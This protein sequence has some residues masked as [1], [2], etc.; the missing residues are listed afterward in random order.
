MFEPIDPDD[1]GDLS[2]LFGPMQV[3]QQIRQAITMCWMSLP[4]ERRTVGRV[5]A[6]VRRIMDRALEAMRE[7]AGRFGFETDATDD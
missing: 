2:H 4:K 5:E 6:E 3:D 7:D 1:H